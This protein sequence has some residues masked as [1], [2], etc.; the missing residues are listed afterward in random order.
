LKLGASSDVSITTSPSSSEST[1]K[2]EKQMTK[3]VSSELHR[4]ILA[5]IG[6][7]VA[8]YADE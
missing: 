8:D 4:N 1:T 6:N 7:V 5:V 3:R 2:Q